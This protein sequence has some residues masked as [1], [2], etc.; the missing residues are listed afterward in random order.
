M[1]ESQDVARQTMRDTQIVRDTLGR[2]QMTIARR[3][4]TKG[5]ATLGGGNQIRPGSEQCADFVK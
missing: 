4:T 2:R 5:S 3:S 1:R